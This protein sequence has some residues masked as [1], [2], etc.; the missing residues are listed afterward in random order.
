MTN[1]ILVLNA[2][3]SSLKFSLFAEGSAD[4]DRVAR[5]QVEGISTAP[6]F[7]AEDAAGARAGEKRWPSGEKIGH[8]GALSHII[9][10]VKEQYAGDHPDRRSTSTAASA[11]WAN[12]C[13]QCSPESSMF[14]PRSTQGCVSLT[15][16][17]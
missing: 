5:G 6:R 9:G 3:S 10:W 17:S 14:A 8:Q 1:A 12:R 2:G 16:S 7:V 11:S 13:L 4:L 15:P